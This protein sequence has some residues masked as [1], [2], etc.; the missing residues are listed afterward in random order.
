MLQRQVSVSTQQMIQPKKVNHSMYLENIKKIKE[1]INGDY[2]KQI[3]I[4]GTAAKSTES[5]GKEQQQ[6]RNARL[7][8]AKFKFFLAQRY[9]G[10]PAEK[11]CH[12]FDF[13]T[14]IDFTSFTN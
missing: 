8:K 1:R 11:L 9:W 5:P 6:Y 2:F 13:T 4:E 10:L 7:T 12:L 3:C 14:P